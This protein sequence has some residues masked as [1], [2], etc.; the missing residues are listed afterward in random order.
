MGSLFDTGA[1]VA[2]VWRRSTAHSA[3]T[4]IGSSLTGVL[5]ILDE[6]R[7]A[8]ISGYERLITT[9]ERLRDLGNT[10]IVVEHDE[11]TIERADHI[12]DVG[13]GAGV[14]AGK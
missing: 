10:V 11:E 12:I 14:W 13:P 6:L 1:G 8:C 7:L 3:A 5:Y 9:F 2:S 4:Q